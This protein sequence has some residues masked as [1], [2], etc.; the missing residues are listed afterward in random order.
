MVHTLETAII[1]PVLI[2]FVFMTLFS[3]FEYARLMSVHAERL[4]DAAEDRSV[5]NTDI[6]RCGDIIYEIFKR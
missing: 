5:S 2:L 6:A 4:Y 1:L 3:A